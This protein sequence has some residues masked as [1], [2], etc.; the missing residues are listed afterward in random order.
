METVLNQKCG[1]TLITDNTTRWNS[2]YYMAK[3]VLQLI[4]PVN[5]VL[6]EMKIDSLLVAEWSHL[7][8][9]VMLLEPFATKTDNLQSDTV[10][11]ICNPFTVRP[12]VS[13]AIFSAP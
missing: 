12:S 6:A 11:L 3:R 13:S 4:G 2:S 7:K 5:D 1:K 8:E 9:L 10:S